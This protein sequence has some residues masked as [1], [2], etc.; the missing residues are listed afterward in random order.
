MEVLRSVQRNYTICADYPRLSISYAT[1]F[2]RQ[3][4]FYINAA[5][6]DTASGVNFKSEVLGSQ[7]ALEPPLGSFAL[8][9]AKG[10]TLLSVPG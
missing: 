5:L 3:I 1:A 10:R 7:Q 6:C 9:S 4:T 8:K 2:T